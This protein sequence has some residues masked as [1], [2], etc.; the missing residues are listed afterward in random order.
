MNERE[1]I[2]F[3]DSDSDEELT[4]EKPKACKANV[5]PI[6]QLKAY[7]NLKQ[8]NKGKHSGS[9]NNFQTATSQQP[10]KINP[11][12]IKNAVEKTECYKNAEA[13]KTTCIRI[14]CSPSSA[15]LNNMPTD[16]LEI[17]C[18]YLDNHNQLNIIAA[19][20]RLVIFLLILFFKLIKKLFNFQIS[21]SFYKFK[22]KPKKIQS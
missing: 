16:V 4:N 8:Q 3:S 1:T 6:P 14:N 7:F 18:N 15:S 17:I 21:R 5:K 20:K 13:Y 9:V 22:H 19:S 12:D 2:V 11:E 10:E